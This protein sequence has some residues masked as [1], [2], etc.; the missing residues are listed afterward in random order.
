MLDSLLEYATKKIKS[1]NN[2]VDLKK[3][4]I[5]LL[6]SNSLVNIKI[7]EISQL[8]VQDRK[9]LGSKFN[10]IKKQI[11]D[12]LNI[13]QEII[14]K[15]TLTSSYYNEDIDV[16]APSRPYLQGSIHPVT[17][18]QEELIKILMHLGFN[19]K[20]G[21]NIESDWYNFSALNMSKNHP[22]RCMHDT[23]YLKSKNDN[24]LLRTHTSPVQIRVME[25]DKPPFKFIAPGRVY[26]SDS[27]ITHTPMFHQIEGL[28]IDKEINMGHLKYVI[29]NIIRNFFKPLEVEI[30]FR[31]SFFPF[32]EPS[33]EVDIRISGNNKWLEV[34]GC[35]I[36]HPNI[37]KNVGLNKKL[38]SGF[39]FGLGVERFAML[40]YG[41]KDL[42]QFFE[43]DMRW[44]KHYSFSCFNTIVKI[45]NI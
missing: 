32:T 42:R 35:G 20:Y 41:I 22:A 6:S 18:C 19:I 23:F 5:E 21:P 3:I 31:P 34:L 13:Q 33:A 8:D 27:D 37:F 25:L 17:Q 2:L 15:Q 1:V 44:L 29:N 4:K 12:L 7:K 16:T 10:N 14:G 26:R 30:R 11:N 40:K 9:I 38:Y 43:G 28:L 45:N 39:A 24:L 36:V